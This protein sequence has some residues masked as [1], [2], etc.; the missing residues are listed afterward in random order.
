MGVTNLA[1]TFVLIL[2]FIFFG[3]SVRRLLSYLQTGRHD[4]RFDRIGERLKRVT[5]VA[6][7]QSKLLR[8]PVAGLTHCAIF[9]GFLVLVVAVIESIGE[10]IAG[11]F[12]FRFLGRFYSLITLSQ[13]VFCLLVIVSVLVALWRR[14]VVRIKRLQVTVHGNIDALL[15]LVWILLIVSSTA[16]KCQPH[17]PW[18]VQP[19]LRYPDRLMSRRFFPDP[20][21][22]GPRSADL[23]DAHSSRIRF[24]E[25]SSVFEAPSRS[26]IDPERLLFQSQRTRCVE[27][28]RPPR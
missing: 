15:I 16:T 19:G 12:S 4:D 23:V 21:L 28:D 9:W 25:L 24:S 2:S 5:K 17:F 20:R 10:G 7:F 8:E 1:F 13:E 18:R 3:M 11:H 26:D 22:R 6:L 27:P 14:F